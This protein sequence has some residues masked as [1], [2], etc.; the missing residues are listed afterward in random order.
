MQAVGG[1]FTPNR[2][3]DDL[4]WLALEETAQGLTRDS[5][6]EVLER[7]MSGPIST[8]TVLLVR[9]GS[10]GSRSE[11][12]G[13]DRLRPLDETGHRQADELVPLLSR[14]DV[15]EL[16]SADYVRCVQT[17]EPLG[18][19]DRNRGQGR[20]APVG[21]GFSGPRSRGCGVDQATRAER[22]LGRH[23][24]PAHGDAEA[25]RAAG[26]RGRRR[27]TAPACQEGRASGR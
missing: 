17:L 9:H 14:F 18:E 11:W 10:A 3:V 1:A 23:L 21:A 6:R 26:G 16:V 24:Q 25:A 22:R 4:R 13:D 12:Q 5:D 7:F 2:E 20:A 8:K 19:V 15:Q 27:A